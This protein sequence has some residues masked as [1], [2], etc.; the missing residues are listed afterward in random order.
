MVR[1]VPQRP[2]QAFPRDRSPD[3]DRGRLAIVRWSKIKTARARIASHY[4][5]RGEVK[6]RVLEALMD[7]LLKP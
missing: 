5:D 6:D 2:G 7:E 4:Y 1:L 3:A